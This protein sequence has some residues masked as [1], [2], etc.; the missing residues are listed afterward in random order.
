MTPHDERSA[1]VTH[2]TAAPCYRAVALQTACHGINRCRSR[3]E[4][5][6][7]IDAAID[8]I[9]QQIRATVA[10]YGASAQ[11]FVLPEYILTGFPMGE[12]VAAWIEKACIT[13][14]GPETDRI[15]THAKAMGVWIAGNS[16]EVD[17]AWPNR[18]FQACWLVGPDG[19]VALKYRR[20]NSLYT[21]SPHDFWTEYR[22]RYSLREIFPV[23]DTPLGQLA[24]IASEE[25]LYPEVARCL[26]MHGAEVFLHSTSDIG[27][28]PRNPK[29]VA[30]LARA[31]EN[32]AFVISANTAGI[33]DTAVPANSADGRSKV[34]DHTGLVLAEAEQGE[35]MV[36]SATVDLAAL[37]RYRRQ[38]GMSNQLA[39]Q[40]FE[41]YAPMY[42]SHS[43]VPPDQAR[44]PITSRAELIA[45]Q[46]ATI[47]R[48]VERGII[49]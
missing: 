24:A 29:E 47:A 26:M 20:L 10:F 31:I 9:A 3:A 34:V 41:L 40:R 19:G 30:K 35:S 23:A 45:L 1:I 22:E 28:H 16:Y 48:L 11:L 4:S 15:G 17:P 14:P 46:E 6:P 39:R 36:A 21:P 37:R 33:F 27:G 49:R 7:L 5:G 25:I 13:I 32:A 12:P 2:E 18:Y 44:S 43:F 8:R 42:Q 38:T